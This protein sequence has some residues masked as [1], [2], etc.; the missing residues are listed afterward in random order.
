MQRVISVFFFV[1]EIESDSSSIRQNLSTPQ[2]NRRISVPSDVDSDINRPS[3]VPYNK[4][5]VPEANTNTIRPI[6]SSNSITNDIENTK[7]P[8]VT[9]SNF[10]ETI[11]PPS[12]M[13][14]KGSSKSSKSKN[15]AS[16]GGNGAKGTRSKTDVNKSSS[17]TKTNNANSDASRVKSEQSLRWELTLADDEKEEERIELYKMNRRKRYL[18]AAQEKG[19][20][21]VVNY[22]SNGS[23]VS[24]DSGLDIPEKDIQHASVNDFSTVHSIMP[25]QSGTPLSLPGELAC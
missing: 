10:D 17:L 8:S 12:N 13:K 7:R 4:R 9:F 15:S 2:E 23:P 24:E 25:S 22:G 19:L 20:G 11:T 1:S 6:R 21:W 14:Q 5:D 16:R 3:I 18:A